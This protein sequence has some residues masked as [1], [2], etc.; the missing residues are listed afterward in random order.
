MIV[1]VV[2]RAA[3]A[4]TR[5]SRSAPAVAMPLIA[6]LTW[7][8]ARL[9]T[10][11]SRVVQQRKADLTEAADESVVGIEMVQAF[12]READVRERFG[13]RAEGVR[14]ERCCA[15][16]A[17]EARYLPRPA[18]SC[19]RWPIASGALLRRPR[20][21]RRATSRSASSCSSTPC[22]C[23]SCGRS[24][25]SAGSSTSA[26][27]A[28]AS[29]GRSFAWLDGVQPLPEP[30]HPAALPAGPAR[31]ALRGRLL[32]LR[33][34]HDVLCE[35]RPRAR[36][37]RDRRRSAASTG[38]GK[39][40]LLN[41]LSR[42]YD[43]TAAACEIGGVDVRA[44]RTADLRTAV[45]L[46][47]Q[48][49]VLFSLPL[50]DNLCAGAARRD[51]GGDA[52]GLR[53]RRRR[54]VHRRPAGR[55]RHAD[56]RA[57]RQPLGRPAPARRARA[58]ADLERAR[59]RARR[60]A[61]G[62][63]HRDRGA[64]VRAAAPGRSPGRTVLLATPAALDRLAGRPR[65]RARGRRDRRGRAAARACC[66]PAARSSACSETRS[67]SRKPPR[68]AHPPVALRR[69]ISAARIA[70]LALRGG[71]HLAPRRSAAGCSCG[72]AIDNGISAHDT[73]AARSRRRDLRRRRTPPPG[74]VGVVPDHAA[75][76]S[77]A[78]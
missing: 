61:L 3:R 32:R 4:S 12:G 23:S 65:G 54:R 71:V 55:L 25:R 7:R 31:R 76:R 53:G 24:R 19:R 57:R 38:S 66:T 59:A 50:R 75:S 68:R 69:A 17:V 40:T 28:I 47:T 44:L 49:P 67:V 36:A 39:S 1:G 21:D 29:A 48:R 64:I 62:G 60:P 51:R 10:P 13:E 43:P 14:D 9:V 11:I 16:R 78:S 26:Q 72:D 5:G 6:L 63:R 56:R 70:L 30:Q 22:S 45:A 46:V 15:R 27:R 42:F 58:R 35:R 52:R 18:R 74:C 2:D 77:S 73:V 41:L 37:G 33:R 34:R 8:F 20:R